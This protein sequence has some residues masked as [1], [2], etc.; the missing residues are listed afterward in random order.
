MKNLTL[1]RLSEDI[2]LEE[3][4]GLVRKIVGKS[5]REEVILSP[6]SVQVM[7][8]DD[9]LENPRCLLGQKIFNF[10]AKQLP[11]GDSSL[12]LGTIDSFRN[13]V[14]EIKFE[15]KDV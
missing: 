4:Q 9:M 5:F 14:R 7:F 8:C 11:S 2:P 13:E 10:V 6:D 15:G 12:R 1:F 3:S